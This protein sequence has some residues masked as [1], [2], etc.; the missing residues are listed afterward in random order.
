LSFVGEDGVGYLKSEPLVCGC[1][2]AVDLKVLPDG[3]C[4]DNVKSL[5][6]IDDDGWSCRVDVLILCV[7]HA[8]VT[9]VVVLFLVLFRAIAVDAVAPVFRF[10]IFSF[11]VV[12]IFIFE[13]Y[14]VG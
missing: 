7:F 11:E 14:Y 2:D 12:L 5:E 10:L 9:D 13:L 4:F 6:A 8:G 1:C 3:S